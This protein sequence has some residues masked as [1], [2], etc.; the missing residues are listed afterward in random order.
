MYSSTIFQAMKDLLPVETSTAKFPL[1]LP[2]VLPNDIS[3]IVDDTPAMDLNVDPDEPS[4]PD[5]FSYAE[6]PSLKEMTEKVLKDRMDATSNSHLH[7]SSFLNVTETPPPGSKPIGSEST[8]PSSTSSSPG[9]VIRK[10]LGFDPEALQDSPPTAMRVIT[11]PASSVS[12]VPNSP[13]SSPDVTPT[14]EIEVSSSPE[15]TQSPTSPLTSSPRSSS[16]G[17]SLKDSS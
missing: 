6:V 17:R 10:V 11:S 16:P 14:P 8:T 1:Q 4:T 5:S 12:T 3:Q 15:G 13:A 2:G 9:A 7:D